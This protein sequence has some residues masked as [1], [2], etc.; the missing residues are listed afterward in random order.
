MSAA[1]GFL[2]G[3]KPVWGVIPRTTTKSTKALASFALAWLEAAD[4]AV[5]E[6]CMLAPELV[7]ECMPDWMP[8]WTPTSSGEE[9]AEWV[10]G[11]DVGTIA[12]TGVVMFMFRFSSGFSSGFKIFL[13]SGL[14]RLQLTDLVANSSAVLDSQTWCCTF[15]S[16]CR[17]TGLFALDQW[18]KFN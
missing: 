15:L 10:K 6:G 5:A 7:P 16:D 12:G 11:E 18:N 17:Q 1:P 9:E 14:N 3:I 8:E 2:A 13:V 4:A